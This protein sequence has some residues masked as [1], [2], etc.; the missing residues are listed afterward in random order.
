MPDAYNRFVG[1]SSPTHYP[2]SMSGFDTP[3]ESRFGIPVE[4]SSERPVIHKPSEESSERSGESS[5]RRD[6]RSTSRESYPEE[7][8]EQTNSRILITF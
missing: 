3:P 4:E 7:S 2:R 5:E 1:T 6:R 8:S